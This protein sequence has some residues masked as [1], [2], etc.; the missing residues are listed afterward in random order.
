MK[1]FTLLAIC[2]FF[3]SA[4]S[5]Q[6]KGSVIIGGTL[7]F[8]DYKSEYFGI[9]NDQ[10]TF[11]FNPKIGK[12][13]ANNRMAGINL[14]YIHSKS[15]DSLSGNTFGAGF[16]LR[17][18]QP[19]GKSFFLFAEEGLNGYTG[20]FNEQNGNP[21]ELKTKENSIN[22]NF[23]PGLAYSINK[24]LQ[25]EI[26]LTELFSLWYTRRTYDDESLPV[27]ARYKNTSFSVNTGF[28]NWGLGNLSFGAR[29]MIVKN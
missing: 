24:K 2:I 10:S 29:W 21:A 14:S 8:Q 5:A 20:R 22:L 1:I 16:F 23:Y 12:F 19:L 13:Y 4:L 7:G 26:G 9:R 27:S 6:Q 17:Q 28:S 18:Y 11:Y 15:R 3:S 25:L